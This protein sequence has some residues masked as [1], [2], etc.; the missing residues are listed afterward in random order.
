MPSSM[1]EITAMANGAG[2]AGA[3]PGF[4][5]HH[6]VQQHQQGLMYPAQLD[7]PQIDRCSGCG[8]V[9]SSL[10][11]CDDLD[12]ASSNNKDGLPAIGDPSQRQ[13]Y[14]RCTEDFFLSLLPQSA[15]E[16]MAFLFAC[17][18]MTLFCFSKDETIVLLTLIFCCIVKTKTKTND[19]LIT[20]N[21]LF[22]FAYDYD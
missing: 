20:N 11:A 5:P 12:R 17:N 10:L 9:D 2:A 13:R 7:R 21:V 1:G 6:S 8:V 19:I 3:G 15:R 16:S 4:I 22:Q 18:T 14:A